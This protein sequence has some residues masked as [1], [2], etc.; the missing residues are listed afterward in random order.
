M[1]SIPKYLSKSIY[2][3]AIRYTGINEWFFLWKYYLKQT[4]I[5]V[6]DSILYSL[7]CSSQIWILNLYFDL[8]HL[9]LK[10]KIFNLMMFNF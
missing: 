4:N 3:T 5:S 10:F 2:C 9:S 7:S 1:K 8:I 6:K